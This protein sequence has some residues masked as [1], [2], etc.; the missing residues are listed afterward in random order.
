MIGWYQTVFGARIVHR[1]PALAFLAFDAKHHRFAFADL[2][3]LK[4]EAPQAGQRGDIG[5]NHVAWSF[6][7]AHDLLA[8]YRRLKA[9]GVLPYRPV[10]HGITLS[11]YYADP[12]GN[13]M[14]FQVEALSVADANSF[15]AGPLFAANPIG[16]IWD[17]DVL[18]AHAE[19]GATE[20][21]L[22]GQP[23]GAKSPIPA[24]HGF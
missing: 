4:P 9:E 13:R 15:M 19:A 22:L 5:V 7:S 21:E 24:A 1:N 12:D 10:H 16:L 2:E 11:L 8:T 18:L 6:A 3:V 14:E 17:P 23:D 20:A